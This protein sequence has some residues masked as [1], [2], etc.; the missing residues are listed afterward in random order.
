MPDKEFD[1]VADP[2]RHHLLKWSQDCRVG[3]APDGSPKIF[4][5]IFGMIMIRRKAWRFRRS[6]SLQ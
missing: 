5:A 1:L 3:E 2:N 4:L 6:F